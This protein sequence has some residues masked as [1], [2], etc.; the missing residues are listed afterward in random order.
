MLDWVSTPAATLTSDP[1]FALPDD[2]NK[3]FGFLQWNQ[4]LQMKSHHY[5]PPLQTLL[6]TVCSVSLPASQVFAVWNLNAELALMT[7]CLS[8]LLNM[9]LFWSASNLPCVLCCCALYWQSMGV[10]C[11]IGCITNYL[12]IG[13]LNVFSLFAHKTFLLSPV[14]ILVSLESQNE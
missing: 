7:F 8:S 14:Y 4:Y 3:V 2:S 12:T 10:Y 9:L 5:E 13:L 1:F 6:N 11:V